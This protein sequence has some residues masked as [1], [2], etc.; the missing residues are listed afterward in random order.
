MLWL[1]KININS[2]DE[3]P[4]CLIQSQTL[5]FDWNFEMGYPEFGLIFAGNRK[6]ETWVR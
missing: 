5:Y 4:M 3:K 6:R 1:K 2:T